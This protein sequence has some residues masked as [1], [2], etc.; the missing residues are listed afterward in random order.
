MFFMLYRKIY[1]VEMCLKP[2]LPSF[3]IKTMGLM[4]VSTDYSCLFLT[5]CNFEY[6][7]N[8]VRHIFRVN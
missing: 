1:V 4:G 2:D 8:I 7:I 6:Y 5:D 3:H